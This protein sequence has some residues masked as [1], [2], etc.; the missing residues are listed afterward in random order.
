M[1]YELP[2]RC[3][4][5]SALA[6]GIPRSHG[7]GDRVCVW[8]GNVVVSP[9][10]HTIASE[11]R[12]LASG[13]RKWKL[14]NWRTR[15]TVYDHRRQDTLDGQA[16]LRVMYDRKGR[17]FYLVLES[18]FD[19]NPPEA[20]LGLGKDP[21]AY[22]DFSG[23]L[24]SGESWFVSVRRMRDEAGKADRENPGEEGQG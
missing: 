16:Y 21:G 7:G 24:K 9:S 3:P 20:I 11:Q 12:E 4:E 19:D 14:G 13:C 22:W 18:I 10:L 23:V 17:Y 1:G 5:C 8:R 2:K 15:L 6:K